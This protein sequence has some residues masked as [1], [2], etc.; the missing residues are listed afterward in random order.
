MRAQEATYKSKRES[1]AS[2]EKWK[3]VL[4]QYADDFSIEI[5]LTEYYK[6]LREAYGETSLSC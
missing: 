4:F 2:L 1:D 3:C 6:L 5:R